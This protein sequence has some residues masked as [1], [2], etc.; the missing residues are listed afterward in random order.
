M[1][2]VS[3]NEGVGRCSFLR[4]VSIIGA[5]RFSCQLG[6]NWKIGKYWCYG[7]AFLFFLGFA[8]SF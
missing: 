4:L 2:V 7:F 1:G 3:F 8:F 6:E 5:L